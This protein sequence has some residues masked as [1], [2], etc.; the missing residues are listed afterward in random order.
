[1]LARAALLLLVAPGAVAAAG[2][3]HGSNPDEGAPD[4]VT[5]V[6]PL[7]ARR[8]FACHGTDEG[9]RAA[10]LRL[11]VAEE[12]RRDRD[13]WA[14]IVPGDHAESEVWLR[15]TDDVDPMPPAEAGAPLAPD[16]L[17]VLRRWIDAGA[18]YAP[19]W[20]YA[21]PVRPE[22]PAAL[23]GADALHPIDRFVR[24]Q[25]AGT[26]LEPSPE[27]DR[28]TLLRR[29]SYDLVGL[30]PTPE[31][32]RAF[33]AD[34]SPGAYE[35]Q[36]ERLLR[37]PHFGERW[38]SVW[39]DL[40]RYADSAG[41]GSDPLRTIWRYRD[42]VIDA[43]DRNLPFDRFTVEQLAGDL[44][45]DATTGTRL[46]TAF[47][48][49][50]MTNTEG[51]TDDEEFRVAAVKDRVNTTFSTWMGLTVGCAECHSHKFDPVSQREYYALFDFFNHTADADRADEAPRI[52]TPTPDQGPEWD[53]LGA[54]LTRVETELAGLG[55]SIDL[56]AYVRRLASQE[57]GAWS[58]PL[59]AGALGADGE[60]LT[61]LG[62]ASIRTLERRES[63]TRTVTLPLEPGAGAPT[64]LRIEALP[65]EALPL[66]GPG[67]NS[68]S[69]N[70]VLTDLR[71]R[72]LPA[73]PHAVRARRVRVV[74][75]GESRYLHLAEVQVFA[76]GV[77]VAEGR[78][79]R[80]SSTNFDGD[81]GRAVDGRTDGA[82]EAGSVSH[83]ARGDDP[84]WE[85]DLGEDRAVEAVRVWNRTDGGLEQRLA[86]AVVE[87]RTE[88]DA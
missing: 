11:D 42:W 26:G 79:A 40:A 67:L 50:T 68:A 15:V 83:T 43:Y 52:P 69:G 30:P 49:N 57:D 12:A 3:T 33:L 23:D 77:E 48:R 74:L 85:V 46:A 75:P 13:G 17:D 51:G 32:V 60:A 64:A 21:A 66:G 35:R 5:E 19:H 56:E 63:G 24:A 61:V 55:G 27:A 22:L 47:H 73:E 31:E 18:P 9:A 8:C 14:A 65:D 1:M 4:Y 54:E 70:F 84:W 25:L 10:G 76:E 80:Q 44:L 53:R 29:L 86:G 45:P 37:S 6:R 58:T 78:A 39:L 34:E 71:V 62:D 41:H 72:A 82:Y 38:A 7:L 16:E 20:A 59:P 87:L 81:A 28:A 88:D 36:V 2:S